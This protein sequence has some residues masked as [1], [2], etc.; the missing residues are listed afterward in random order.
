MRQ[1]GTKLTVGVPGAC[2]QLLTRATGVDLWKDPV[3]VS[4]LLIGTYCEETDEAVIAQAVAAAPGAGLAQVFGLLASS[5]RYNSVAQ[6][7]FAR[8]F[9]SVGLV[10]LRLL[11]VMPRP[12]LLQYAIALAGRRPSIF[13]GIPVFQSEFGGALLA[14]VNDP[15]LF[16]ALAFATLEPDESAMPVIDPL[17]THLIAGDDAAVRINAET[18]GQVIR[19]LVT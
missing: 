4:L 10:V 5:E 3:F 7:N 6:I 12:G 17:L 1:A 13:V 9:T 14:T 8:D 2:L 11:S 15:T 19:H 18:I 16:S